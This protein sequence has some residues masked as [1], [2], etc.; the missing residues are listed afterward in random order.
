MQPFDEPDEVQPVVSGGDRLNPRDALNH[1]LMI[2]TIDL[3]EDSP[4]KYGPSDVVVVDVVDLE[5]RTLHRK[6]WWRQSR[7]VQQLQGK[8]GRV[9]PTLAWMTQGQGTGFTPPYELTSANGH[10]QAM[11]IAMA[12]LHENPTFKP[13]QPGTAEMNANLSAQEAKFRD[14]WQQQ[15][16]ASAVTPPPPPAPP[17]PPLSMLDRIKAS[18]EPQSDLAATGAAGVARINEMNQRPPLPPPPPLPDKPPY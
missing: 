10:Q 18:R 9:T 5:T 1:L 16:V 14:P 11:D 17:A 6:S 2:W 3:I 15:R 7:L 8:V 4:S 13:S 12:W